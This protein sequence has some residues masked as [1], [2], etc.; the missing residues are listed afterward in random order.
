MMCKQCMEIFLNHM[1]KVHMWS[2]V[3]AFIGLEEPELIQIYGSWLI[4]CADLNLN[5][6]APGTDMVLAD[7]IDSSQLTWHWLCGTNGRNKTVPCFRTKA[8]WWWVY[9]CR[10][11]VWHPGNEEPEAQSIFG[12]FWCIGNWN[13]GTNM[14]CSVPEEKAGWCVINYVIS[15]RWA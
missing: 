4:V 7:L 11:H 3:K 9:S 1:T 10:A 8:L 5:K 6:E 2:S 14:G 15:W 12:H 13:N